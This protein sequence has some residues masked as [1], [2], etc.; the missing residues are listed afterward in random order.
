MRI[1]VIMKRFG[2]NKDMIAHNFGRQVNLFKS[3]RKL[4]HKIDF[5]CP[6]YKKL[7]HINIFKNKVNYYIRPY[8][9][10]RHFR[11]MKELNH[12]V[13]KG[14]YDFIVGSSD[15]LLGILGYYISKK[16]KIKYI[17]DMQDEY[18]YYDTYKIPLV[19]CLDKNAIKNS[20]IVLTVSDSLNQHISKFRKKH[21]YTIQNGVDLKLFRK[22]P[23]NTARKILKLPKGK[24]IIYVGE[25]SRFKGADVLIEAFKE[26]KKV[27]PD[28]RLLLSGKILD[29]I[30]IKQDSIIYREYPH[31]EEVALALNAADVSVVPNRKNAF[32]E[33]C[34]PYK[35][36]EYM[37]VNLPVVSTNVGDASI[38][39]SRY[40]DSLCKPN[41]KYDLADK[42]IKK[43][44]SKE[45]TNYSKIV[46]NLTWDNLAKKL[47]KIIKR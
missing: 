34:F 38:I 46:N 25:I 6:D 47:D 24:I 29:N 11:F 30:D 35:L 10:T 33:Y 7:E 9:I 37:A 18:S 2:A 3:L 8:S 20:D 23:K 17:Y 12:L 26:V 36:L 13:K 32:S 45:K 21:V 28:V 19:K 22:V 40:K 44:S 15:P 4:G 41:D 1:L 14:A 5:L 31:R 27:I 42:I 43:I 39:L 16:Y